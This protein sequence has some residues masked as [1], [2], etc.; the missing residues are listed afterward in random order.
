VDIIS[1]KSKI[2][3]LDI[4]VVLMHGDASGVLAHSIL[5]Q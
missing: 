2:V 4:V 1:S 3:C 5:G